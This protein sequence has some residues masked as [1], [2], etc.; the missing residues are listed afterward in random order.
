MPLYD[1]KCGEG[2]R[3]ERHVPLALF[4]E[5]QACDCGAPSQRL[6]SAPRVVSDVIEPIYGAD[7]RL[8]DSLSGYRHSLT[9]EGNPKGERYFELGN[10]S[11]PEYRPPKPDMAAIADAVKA[12][13]ADVKAGRTTP[14]VTGDLP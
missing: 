3:F 6:V 11:L 13:M 12:G 8:H 1:F 5:V 14:V 10:E 2:H 4:S 7:G 9:P